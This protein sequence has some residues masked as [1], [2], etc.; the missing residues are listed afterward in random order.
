MVETTCSMQ[1]IWLTYSQ[2]RGEDTGDGAQVLAL[3]EL[4]T[5]GR[6]Q[7]NLVVCVIDFRDELVDEWR[8]VS[9]CCSAILTQLR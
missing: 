5:T 6:E 9:Q 1:T 3:K 2:E 8:S 7:G 4:E